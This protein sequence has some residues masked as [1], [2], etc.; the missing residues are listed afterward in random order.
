[1]SA[2][3][4][5]TLVPPTAVALGESAGTPIVFAAPS[6]HVEPLSPEPLSTVIPLAAAPA[7]T[8][9][10]ACASAAGVWSSHCAHEFE[11]TV[12]PSPIIAWNICTKLV[13]AGAS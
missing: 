8:E 13:L 10:I 12:S 6:P 4:K 1:M 5:V 7:S 11:I 9:S 2:G 3:P